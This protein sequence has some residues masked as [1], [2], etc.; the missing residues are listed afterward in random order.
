M[1]ARTPDKKPP[2]PPVTLRVARMNGLL[3]EDRLLIADNP[4]TEPLRQSLQK[5]RLVKQGFRKIPKPGSNETHLP[6]ALGYEVWWIIP[7]YQ[8]PDGALRTPKSLGKN[9]RS[10]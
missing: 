6:D 4:T 10:R 5:C 7:R 3:A 2:H 1:R 9:W 8:Q